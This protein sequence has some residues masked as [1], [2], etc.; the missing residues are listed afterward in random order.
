MYVLCVCVS[1]DSGSSSD[2]NPPTRAEKCDWSSPEGE[3]A[4]ETEKLDVGEFSIL[5]YKHRKESTLV[6]TD[7]ALKQLSPP[8]L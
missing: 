6:Q 4:T 8:D 5:S 3:D 2:G 1:V 7:H